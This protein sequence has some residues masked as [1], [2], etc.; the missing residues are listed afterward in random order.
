MMMREDV[1]RSVSETWSDAAA[2]IPAVT[3]GT[4]SKGTPAALRASSLLGQAAEDGRVSVLE[5][6]NIEAAARGSDHAG[7]DFV[8]GDSF[9]AAAFAD[10]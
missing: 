10:V 2:A 1:R 8:L 9:R 6:D 4:T 7:V 5:P 3:P